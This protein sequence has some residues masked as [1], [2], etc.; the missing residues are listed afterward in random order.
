M[1][2]NNI[3]DVVTDGIN[4]AIADG[5]AYIDYN[6]DDTSGSFITG[7][8]TNTAG[9]NNVTGDPG[10]SDPANGDF[11]LTAG[12]NCIAAGLSIGVNE[13]VKLG[14]YKVNIG[15]DQDDNSAPFFNRI[16]NSLIGR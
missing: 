15:A 6:C 8:S 9:P 14:D 11:T 3:F 1:I 12:S 10:L 16:S 13:G 4:W 2:V 5:T 7:S